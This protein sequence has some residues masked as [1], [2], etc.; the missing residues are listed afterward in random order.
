MRFALCAWRNSN[1]KTSWGYVHANMP[2]IASASLSGWRWGKCARCATCQFYSL[3]SRQAAQS[4]RRPSSN[5]CPVSR[6]WCSDA[7]ASYSTLHTSHSCS[8]LNTW[9]KCE[10]WLKNLQL[11]LSST[12]HILI[13]ALTDNPLMVSLF[14]SHG[15]WRRVRLK[16]V[17]LL[18]D[19]VNSVFTAKALFWGHQP[20]TRRKRTQKPRTIHYYFKQALYEKSTLNLLWT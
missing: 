9:D 19:M 12:V 13:S 7:S 5:L 10:D 3:P 2:F 6:T 20:V 8:L 4:P 15:H 11:L 17:F 14:F 1:R 16:E 18:A